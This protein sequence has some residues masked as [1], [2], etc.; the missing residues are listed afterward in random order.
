MMKSQGVHLG[1]KN[2]DGVEVNVHVYVY[3][4]RLVTCLFLYQLFSS[5]R[6]LPSSTQVDAAGDETVFSHVLLKNNH[7]VAMSLA[8][9]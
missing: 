4:A 5:M 1:Y 3:L 9:D 6:S 8:C 7:R 2:A